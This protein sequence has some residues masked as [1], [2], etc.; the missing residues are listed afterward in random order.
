MIPILYA[1]ALFV[2]VLSDPDKILKIG[3]KPPSRLV[4]RALSGLLASEI[5]ALRS[6]AIG[7][8]LLAVAQK[9]PANAQ[10]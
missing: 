2:N 3:F 9:P 1:R 5:W 8:Y 6:P 10:T 4:G 7:A